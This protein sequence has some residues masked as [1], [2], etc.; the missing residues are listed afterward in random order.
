[1]T[2]AQVLPAFACAL[3]RAWKQ[4]ELYQWS[5]DKKIQSR[6]AQLF[7]Q[8]KGGGGVKREKLDAEV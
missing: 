4:F 3:G 8:P 6:M 1:M 2:I 7:H 5:P